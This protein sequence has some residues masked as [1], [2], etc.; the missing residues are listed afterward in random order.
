MRIRQEKPF[1]YGYNPITE[2]DGKH[3]NMLMDFGILKM[4]K[5]QQEVNEEDK[6]RAYLL[7]QG[8]VVLKWED[9]KAEIKRTSCFDENPW[10]LHVP[11]GVEVKVTALGESELVVQ[12]TDND[13]TFPAKLYTQEECRSEQF[14]AG[15]MNETSTR[16]VR[17]IFDYSNA[18]YS[19]M[20]IGEVIDHPGKWSSY[21]PHDHPQPEVYYY[22]FLPEQGFGVSIIGEDAFV[23]KNNDTVAIPGGLVHPQVSAPGYAM[24]YCWMIRHLKDNPFDER[25]FADEHK[26][27]LD[28]DAKIWPER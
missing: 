14:G 5:G 7:I 13:R 12:K 23:I 18:P 10:C 25:I 21:P 16:T 24:Y 8:E 17:T 6:E 20:V 4:Q 2:I 22:R 28:K 26:W 11:S 19:N 9:N 1:H 27:L 15:T 3:S